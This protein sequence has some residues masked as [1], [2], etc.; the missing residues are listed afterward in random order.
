MISHLGFQW[1]SPKFAQPSAHLFDHSVKRLYLVDAV[2]GLPGAGD[3]G[4]AEE[5][6]GADVER[7]EDVGRRV[8]VDHRHLRQT[9][10]INRAPIAKYREVA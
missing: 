8:C 10:G 5:M 6:G 9:E 2:V 1:L 7:L 4:Y 3:G